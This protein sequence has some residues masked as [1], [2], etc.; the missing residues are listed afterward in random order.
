MDNENKEKSALEKMED[1]LKDFWRKNGQPKIIAAKH[2]E[3][4]IE[5]KVFMG[6]QVNPD[7]LKLLI[8]NYL[9]NTSKQDSGAGNI[10][11]NPEKLVIKTPKGKPLV[12]VRDKQIIQEYLA[13]RKAA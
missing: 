12:I 13:A 3:F 9:A 7:V 11:V 4:I 2:S 6:D 8:I 1:M 10:D 5:P